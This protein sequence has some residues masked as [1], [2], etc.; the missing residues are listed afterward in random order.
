MFIAIA[1]RPGSMRRG[2]NASGVVSS[3]AARRALGV[4][5]AH[6]RALAGAGAEVGERGGHG[7]LADAALA[8]DEQQAA[9][10]QIALQDQPPKPIRRSPS[11]APSSM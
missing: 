5:L 4:H 9:I 11:L 3:V 6:E 2:S 8:G 7:G 1:Y 10:E